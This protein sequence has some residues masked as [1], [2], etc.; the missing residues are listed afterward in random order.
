MHQIAVAFIVLMTFV[1]FVLELWTGCAIVGWAGDRSVIEREKSP[2][3]YWS[4]MI[5]QVVII[6]V[7]AA[8]MVHYR[9]VIFGET[10]N[11]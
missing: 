5:F 10:P 8:L 4:V 3:P 9:G 1:T 6:A 7:F 2:G 11:Q